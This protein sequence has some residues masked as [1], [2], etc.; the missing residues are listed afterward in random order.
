MINP[1]DGWTLLQ[2]P[3]LLWHKQPWSRQR[4]FKSRNPLGETVNSGRYALFVSS[5]MVSCSEVFLCC[6]RFSLW[7]IIHL[8]PIG[9]RKRTGL[10]K[11]ASGAKTERKRGRERTII[12]P[13]FDYQLTHATLAVRRRAGRLASGPSEGC[14]VT[15]PYTYGQSARFLRFSHSQLRSSASCHCIL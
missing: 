8:P 10:G 13:C 2:K 7:Q 6:S 12:S 4:G 3:P 11:G 9:A 14:R 1:T 5:Y 15:K